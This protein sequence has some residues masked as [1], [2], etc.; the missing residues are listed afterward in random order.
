[1]RALEIIHALYCNAIWT[2]RMNVV[3]QN[4][5]RI[6]RRCEC[7]PRDTNET[8]HNIRSCMYVLLYYVLLVTIGTSVLY[9]R[10]MIFFFLS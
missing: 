3:N 10:A 9:H 1:M 5:T 8:N 2:A 4:P 7:L 6:V